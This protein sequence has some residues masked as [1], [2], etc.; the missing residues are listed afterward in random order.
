MASL[1]R[2][3]PAW[4]NYNYNELLE[5]RFSDLKIKLKETPL[6][7]FVY[8]LYDELDYRQIRFKPRCWL[9]DEWFS[10]DSV[11]GIAMPF[12]L[13]HPKLTKLEAKQV[14]EVEG[15]TDRS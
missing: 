1:R 13:A 6:I 7:Q 9:S 12:Y 14:Y 10:P 5:L 4:A 8:Q 15:G 11:P 2:K 3:K